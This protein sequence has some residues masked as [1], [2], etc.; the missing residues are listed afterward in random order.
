MFLENPKI[1][2]IGNFNPGGTERPEKVRKVES[3]TRPEQR[4]NSDVPPKSSGSA[5]R[6]EDG[7]QTQL[8]DS[9]VPRPGRSN[10][11]P[12]RSSAGRMDT[13]KSYP[14]QRGNH[15]IAKE[16]GNAVSKPPLSPARPSG[17]TLKREA[18]S[19]HI[20]VDRP[21]VRSVEGSVKNPVRRDPVVRETISKG[22][23][24][25]SAGGGQTVT[26]GAENP[27]PEPS[28]NRRTM[29]SDDIP[30]KGP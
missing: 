8:R 7:N 1:E 23:S 26:R 18:G 22:R 4:L 14:V 28:S 21:P 3:I 25:K 27:G 2:K 30:E 10:N 29:G 15:P 16:D 13:P 20:K 6:R 19:N 9:A 5:V 24:G 12:A 17:P 11:I